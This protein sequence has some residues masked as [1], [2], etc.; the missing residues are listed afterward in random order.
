MIGCTLPIHPLASTT[1][2]RVACEA[3][4]PSSYNTGASSYRP[5]KKVKKEE[6]YETHD[7]Y[8]WPQ[9]RYVVVPSCMSSRKQLRH[10]VQPPPPKR[11]KVSHF[12]HNKYVVPKE[13]LIA[14][15]LWRAS[16]RTPIEW[17]N[18]VS[19]YPASLTP[20]VLPQPPSPVYLHEEYRKY[21]PTRATIYYGPE[22]VIDREERTTGKFAVIKEI[23][24]TTKDYLEGKGNVDKLGGYSVKYLYKNSSTVYQKVGRVAFCDVTTYYD[25]YEKPVQRRGTSP[26]AFNNIIQRTSF[27]KFSSGPYY[28]WW[29]ALKTE[30]F[31]PDRKTIKPEGLVTHVFETSTGELERYK[32]YRY[33]PKV[34]QGRS[35][36]SKNFHVP[37]QIRGGEFNLGIEPYYEHFSRYWEEWQNYWPYSIYVPDEDKNKYL[38]SRRIWIYKQLMKVWVVEA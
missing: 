30:L 6:L 9:A 35:L 33:K 12:N 31:P 24:K 37:K 28:F 17:K 16:T 32:Y 11:F 15:G 26:G 13:S 34:I 14:N 5:L 3:R 8:N 38:A 25:Q 23:D 21:K 20:V 29:T 7:S 36:F 2:E 27:K 1:S 4:T 18:R 22:D 19:R 10:Y